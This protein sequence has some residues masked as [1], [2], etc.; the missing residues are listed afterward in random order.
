[1]GAF[2]LTLWIHSGL[3]PDSLNRPCKT[4]GL[5]TDRLYHDKSEYMEVFFPYSIRG[6]MCAYGQRMSFTPQKG[7]LRPLCAFKS[8]GFNGFNAVEWMSWIHSWIF[9]RSSKSKSNGLNGFKVSNRTRP[10]YM[11]QAV[12]ESRQ[13]GNPGNL[14]ISPNCLGNLG[15]HLQIA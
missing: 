15:Y 9:W 11:F 6:S 1:M 12:W 4:N 2:D 14:G 7:F 3:S 10:V 5:N 8:D 13:P